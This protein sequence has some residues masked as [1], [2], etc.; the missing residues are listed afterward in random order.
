MI[1]ATKRGVDELRKQQDDQRHREVRQTLL[2]WLSA[3]DYTNQRN[4]ILARRQA[5]TGEWLLISKEFKDWV[6][7]PKQMLFCWGLPG[8]GKT[9]IAAIVID[10]LETRFQTD[11]NVG[12]A[13]LFCDFKLQDQKPEGLLRSLLRQLVGERSVPDNVIE[14]FNQYKLKREPPLLKDI[15]K[16]LSSVI[17]SYSRVFIVVDALDECQ[18]RCRMSFVK[19][20]L[21]LQTETE[22]NIFATSRAIPDVVKAF[23]GRASLEIRASK[24][25]VQ[26]YI[27]EN[28]CQLPFCV[29]RSKSLQDEIKA[30]I[31][32]A[33]DG[34]YVVSS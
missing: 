29:Q 13:Y 16:V 34:M 9:I 14:L 28:L 19:E 15:S 1:S 24:E 5:G 3:T 31:G 23:E 22:V 12:I 21:S 17:S 8:A 27:D 33:A 18:T 10:S 11:N 7:K 32:K 25:D 2:N 26:N 20:M 30:E 6:E 4:D